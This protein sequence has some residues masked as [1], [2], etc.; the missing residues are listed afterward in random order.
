[1]AGH[2]KDLISEQFNQIIDVIHEGFI[3]VDED[4][5]IVDVNEVY[6]EMVGYDREE[7]LSMSVHQL[8]TETS[9]EEQKQFVQE[10]IEKE[11]VELET[12][13]LT[14]SGE[15]INLKASVGAVKLEGNTY[16][17]AL[18]RDVTKEI[19]A[20][21]KLR[22]SEQQFKSLFKHNPHPVY[23]FDLEGNFIRVNERLTEFTGLT[24]KELLSMKFMPF[25]HEDDLD[26]TMKQFKKA[27]SGES[28][29]Y[30]IRVIVRDGEE[31]EI[32]VTNFPMYRGD[33][34]AGVYGILEDKT[35]ANNAKRKLEE[36]EQRWQGLVENNP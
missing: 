33:E 34:I 5:D 19:K 3:L 22:Q 17:A 36:S 25:I 20:K 23:L 21:V 11:S 18:V 14:K 30:E 12:E 29:Q 15:K 6:C 16:L 10:L 9:Q 32:R 2:K 1:M 8:R 35:E 28:T 4:A 26:H 31:K 24:R 7:L 27:A 13:H